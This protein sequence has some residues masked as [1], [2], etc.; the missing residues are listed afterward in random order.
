MDSYWSALREPS[1]EVCDDGSGV[2][3]G[4]LER[5]KQ[6]FE[7]GHATQ[8]LPS[9]GLGLGLVGAVLENHAGRLELSR[10]A[11]GGLSA[12]LEVPLEKQARGY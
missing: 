11:Q 4:D 8:H 3:E 10:V 6:P 2:S 9:A 7:R 1:S 5:L 12:R